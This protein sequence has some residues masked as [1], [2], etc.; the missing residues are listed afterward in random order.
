[1]S[2]YYSLLTEQ[3]WIREFWD[4]KRNGKPVEVLEKEKPNTHKKFF[5]RCNECGYS[6]PKPITPK[7]I[8]GKLRCPECGDG[9]SR[10]VT[11]RN[12][13][14]ALFPQIAKELA[15]G[16][17]EGITGWNIRPSYRERRLW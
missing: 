9:K 14:A 3:P 8:H 6:F 13:L 12:C 16:L 5:F 1:M 17:N 4:E 11:E 10:E 15:D 7:D 2:P